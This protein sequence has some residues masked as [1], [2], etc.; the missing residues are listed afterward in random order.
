MWF[1]SRLLGGF[2]AGCLELVQGA[3]PGGV[4]FA[5]LEIVDILRFHH[6]GFLS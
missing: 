3:T 2:V 4:S 5:L 1:G 6:G